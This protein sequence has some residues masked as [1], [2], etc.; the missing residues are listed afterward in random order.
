MREGFDGSVFRERLLQGAVAI[1]S[2]RAGMSA[3]RPIDSWTAP[4]VSVYRRV[5]VATYPVQSRRSM[6]FFVTDSRASR[7]MGPV[8]G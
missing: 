4:R 5:G 6:V 7:E 8:T 3:G 2:S 1:V